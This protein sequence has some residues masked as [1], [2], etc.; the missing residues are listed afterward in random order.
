[1]PRKGLTRYLEIAESCTEEIVSGCNL[2][3]ECGDDD[4][5]FIRDVIEEA[6]LREED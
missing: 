1:M 5:V 3:I 6:L 2:D 4:W